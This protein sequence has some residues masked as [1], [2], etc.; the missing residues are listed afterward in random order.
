[1]REDLMFRSL[2]PKPLTKLMGDK[3]RRYADRHFATKPEL[4]EV[5]PGDGGS[6]PVCPL[7]E[8]T[9]NRN[10]FTHRRKEAS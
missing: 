5:E 2:P 6:Q 1:V 9:K 7:Y 10:L 8:G 4:E 3:L